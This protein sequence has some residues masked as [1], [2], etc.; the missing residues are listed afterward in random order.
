M[1]Y[2]KEHAAISRIAQEV[3]RLT[4]KHF[5]TILQ[6]ATKTDVRDISSFLDHAIDRVIRKRIS[7]A[8]PADILIT[9]EFSPHLDPAH[10]RAWVVDPLCGSMNVAR[11]VKFF[12]TNIAL[13]EGGKVVAAWVIDH[14]REELIWGLGDKKVF[15]SAKA[16]R[17]LK[18]SSVMSVVEIEQAYYYKLPIV[19]Q[20]RIARFTAD[21][22]LQKNITCYNYG[23][24]LGF[25]YVATGQ[26]QAAVTVN[27]YPWDF[28]AACFLIEQNGGIVT[29]F[30][31]TPWNIRSKSIVMAGDKNIHRTLL[32]LLKKNKLDNL[33]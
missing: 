23:S 24:S 32:R 28:I 12:A 9:E 19:V 11:G 29:N 22:L 25:A 16:V 30:N 20:E 15:Q 4:K 18:Y 26:L 21:A 31:G 10:G 8:F 2:H 14:A 5:G 17:R 27:I 7:A 1:P 13:V 33:T 3:L 6:V